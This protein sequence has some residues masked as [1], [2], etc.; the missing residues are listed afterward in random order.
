MDLAIVID[1]SWSVGEANFER[2]I[3][4]MNNIVNSLEF[5]SGK[6]QLAILTFNDD[7]KVWMNLGQYHKKADV[8]EVIDNMEYVGGGTFTADALRVLREDIFNSDNQDRPSAPNVAILVT[9]GVSNILPQRTIPEAQNA[10]AAGIHIYGI[11]IG[12]NSTDEIGKIVSDKQSLYLINNYH[13]LVD[14]STKML[15]KVCSMD[16]DDG[17]HG[18]AAAYSGRRYM[19]NPVP[20][21]GI[22]F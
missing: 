19:M 15:D 10:H 17:R 18:L 12:L 5:V 13:E 2:I 14:F 3:K 7:T 16:D 20:Q 9:D 1:T 6:T 8:I 11:G 4:F 22:I 21:T